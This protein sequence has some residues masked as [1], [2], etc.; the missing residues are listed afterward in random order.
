MVQFGKDCLLLN[1]VPRR[2]D[3]LGCCCFFFLSETWAFAHSQ[4]YASNFC[5]TLGHLC[6]NLVF[7]KYYNENIEQIRT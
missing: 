5:L 2:V 1:V 4:G 3:I 6:V 7:D